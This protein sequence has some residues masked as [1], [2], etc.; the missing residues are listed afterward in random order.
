MEQIGQLAGERRSITF[1]AFEALTSHLYD[2]GSIL[3]LVIPGEFV[4]GSRLVAEAF[5]RVLRFCSLHNNERFQ[6]PI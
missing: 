3:V 2:L 1:E 6:T 4:V 5:L